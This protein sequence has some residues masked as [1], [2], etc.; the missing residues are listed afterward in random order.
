MRCLWIMFVTAVCFLFL[1]KLKWPKTKNIQNRLPLET[2]SAKFSA[3]TNFLFSLSSLQALNKGIFHDITIKNDNNRKNNAESTR[4]TTPQRSL[5]AES[6]NCEIL[7]FPTAGRRFDSKVKC[8]TGRA[9]FGS[10]F[11]LYGA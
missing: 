5:R 11:P 1:L 10:N 8:P 2:S 4:A 3:T 6:L 9:S 7:L